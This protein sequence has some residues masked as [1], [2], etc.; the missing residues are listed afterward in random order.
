M[1]PDGFS[2]PLTLA[3]LLTRLKSLFI[4]ISRLRGSLLR[5]ALFLTII[6]L[7]WIG[8]ILLHPVRWA[9]L[10]LA[11]AAAGPILTLGGY[12]AGMLWP[13]WRVN[14]MVRLGTLETSASA[15][16]LWWLLSPGE[17]L[18]LTWM[19]IFTAVTMTLYHERWSNFSKG[20][21]SE[22]G[23]GDSL[24]EFWLSTSDG[25]VL[26]RDE[27]LHHGPALFLFYRGDW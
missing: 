16:W 12:L 18:V 10:W 17:A 5:Q 9:P 25:I 19:P 27:A 11:A 7:A 23:V 14:W 21:L 2:H 3:L 13:Y 26:S 8:A 20:N 22:L 6:T 1:R 24:P 15:L 4:A